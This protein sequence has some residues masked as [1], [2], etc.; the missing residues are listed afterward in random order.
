MLKC[1][2]K[3]RQI[4][5]RVFIPVQTGLL[6]RKSDLCNTPGLVE[7][8]G[9]DKE[10]LTLQRSSVDQAGNTTV[11]PIVH[12]VLRSPG[13]SLDSNTRSFMEPR[14]GHDFSKVR[15]HTDAKA[16]ESARAMN[17]VAYTVG[18]KVVFE[19]GEYA[20]N[21]N[22]GRRLL[23][24]ELTHVIQQKEFIT[25]SLELH[26]P[27]YIP[28]ASVLIS[29]ENDSE[30]LEAHRTGA[31]IITAESTIIP[32]I[33]VI[34]GPKLMRQL[35][36][37]PPSPATPRPAPALRPGRIIREFRA[38]DG[39]VIDM[40]VGSAVKRLGLENTLPCGT[41]VN[42]RGWH[43]AHSVGPGVGA[44]SGV[45]IR[46]AP[47][48]VNLKYQ[49]SGIEK[50]IRDFNKEKAS[51]VRLYLRTVTKTHP[52]SRRLKSITYR[53]S[54][55][56]GEAR[57]THLFEVTI[58]IQ[59][60]TNNPR[61]WLKKPFIFGEYTKFLAPKRTN[62]KPSPAAAGS[63]PSSRTS[64][65]SG[66][67]GSPTRPSATSGKG[68]KT[69]RV[70]I[71]ETSLPKVGGPKRPGGIRPKGK[72]GRVTR[73]GINIGAGIA[74][75]LLTSLIHD[76]FLESVRNMPRPT[77]QEVRL[78]KNKGMEGRNALDLVASDLPRLANDFITGQVKYSIFVF[79]FW[80][81]LD[82]TSLI[83]T[84]EE[85]LDEFEQA[86]LKHQ[87]SLLEA[88]N[89]VFKALQLEPR[90]REVIT[91]A[92]ELLVLTGPGYGENTMFY[93][94]GIS[95][96]DIRRIQSNLKWFGKAHRNT[97][98]ALHKLDCSLEKAI[99]K[100]ERIFDQI[101]ERRI[102]GFIEIAPLR[103]EKKTKPEDRI[104]IVPY[105]EQPEHV[106]RPLDE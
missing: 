10:K 37:T 35:P 56:G 29:K 85:L 76:Q 38:P 30:E 67:G 68:G 6:Q 39:I 20:P 32:S 89:N 100:N 25:K 80:N 8:S 45:G 12:E 61:V 53:L 33:S 36:P 26:D 2:P 3:C 104:E 106:I 34:S 40:E 69:A 11:P 71:P 91:A 24:H 77:I 102:K 44:E 62:T 15:V 57:P 50:F 101:Q 58:G 103:E 60:K 16:A 65:R 49:N 93:V 18:R 83:A 19:E 14:F 54:A 95:I 5:R 82:K 88:Q 23:A 27:D 47:P 73:G 90:M 22:E 46:Y 97:L 21:T 94:G 9:R 74:V 105:K 78:W 1:K 64:L 81:D 48:E 59:N 28:K 51:D 13:K 4:L 98:E 72:I 99:K 66:T 42:L 17:S 96:E 70:G 43:R 87:M 52:N 41:K 79:K 31:Q 92:E 75:S 84:K 63:A 55:A 7:D 86:I